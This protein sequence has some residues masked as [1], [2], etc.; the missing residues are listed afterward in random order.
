MNKLLLSLIC[1]LA[2]LGGRSQNVDFMLHQRIWNTTG[3][4][5]SQM[6]NYSF[7]YLD[8]AKFGIGV[9][10]EN[11]HNSGISDL[12]IS[13][14][15]KLSKATVSASVVTLNT[16]GYN[17]LAAH[18]T[19]TLPLGKAV[20]VGASLDYATLSVPT[21]EDLSSIDVSVSTALRFTDDIRIEF[22]CSRLLALLSDENTWDSYLIL[23]ST[24]AVTPK[25]SICFSA[26]KNKT[27]DMSGRLLL[28]YRP[29]QKWR[30]LAGYQFRPNL[31]SL[32]LEFSFNDIALGLMTTTHAQLNNNFSARAQYVH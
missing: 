7:T 4:F 28:D 20:L 23:R 12:N 13:A 25:T 27:Q 15:V 18:L 2:F 9:L 8:S 29:H 16:E 17:Q 21:Y 1:I 10:Y 6:G 11:L 22:L 24:Y 19:G 31:F 30:L 14:A 32:G 5:G 26:E 3:T